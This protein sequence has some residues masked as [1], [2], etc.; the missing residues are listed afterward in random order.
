VTE[1]VEELQETA[2][3]L[4]T[5]GLMEVDDYFEDTYI[6]RSGRRGQRRSPYFSKSMWN[7][8]KRTLEGIPRTNNR[9]EGWHR[10][11]QSMVD[12]VHPSLF[13]LLKGLQREE[14]VQSADLFRFR[15]GQVVKKSEKKC[16]DAKTRL[17]TLISRYQDMS[18]KY[19]FRGVGY[20]INL[21]V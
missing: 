13:R 6:G 5:P 14:N 4:D 9:L 15:P 12:S 16:M 11:I 7:V 17:K 19:L 20:N 21:N 8:K 1:I 10:G 3:A 18:R 2:I